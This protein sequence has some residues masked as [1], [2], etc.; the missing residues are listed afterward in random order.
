MSRKFGARAWA[1]MTVASTAA[2]LLSLAAVPASASVSQ[3]PVVTVVA[4]HLN[5]PRHITF[6][7]GGLYVTEAGTGGK[8]CVTVDKST[9]CEGE[10]GAVVLVTRHGI[11][12]MLSGLPSIRNDEGKGGVSAVT[13]DRGR[14][15]V[16][17]QDD[18][19]KADGTSGVK[20]PGANALGKVLLA[21]PFAKPGNWRIAADLAK[22]A[23]KHPQNPKTLGGVPGTETTYDSDPFNIIAYRGGYAIA[24]AA[25]NDVLW[26]SPRGHLSV[27][28]RLP[29]VPETV[30]A[31]VF[32]P[33]PV[34]I[35]AQAVPTS[36]AIGPHGALYVGVLRGVPSLPG[37]ADVY[38]VVPG[39][40]P[41]V[42]V[43][44]LTS[45][46]SIAFDR[47]G[48]LLVLVYNDGGLTAPAGTPGELLR[49]SHGKVSLLG[50]YGLLQPSG[51]AVGPDGAVYVTNHGNSS[52]GGQVLRITGLG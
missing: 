11:K 46:S 32:G 37:T 48:R 44:G 45:V 25:A 52:G 42:A 22:F 24:D 13:F 38:R 47:Q 5:S 4:S 33:N 35:H 49:V 18:M 36:L 6:G 12:T 41:V 30:P 39:R 28:S 34:T 15:A 27:L 7:P 16:V 50:V 23:S 20:G 8:S 51:L 9:D 19:V 29:T 3:G 17:L 40:A 14:L 31:G 43:R 2:L 1:V 10:T 26:L 21:R